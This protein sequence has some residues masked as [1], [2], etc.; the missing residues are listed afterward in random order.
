MA[1]KKFRK[2]PTRNKAEKQLTDLVKEAIARDTAIYFF[3]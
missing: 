1:L 3:F 2:W